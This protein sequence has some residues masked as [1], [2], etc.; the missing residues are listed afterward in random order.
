MSIDLDDLLRSVARRAG[1]P[2]APPA[3]V[4][5]LVEATLTALASELPTNDVRALAQS[6]PTPLDYALRASELQGEFF[7]RI[8]RSTFVDLPAATERA[9]STLRALGEVLPGELLSRI[10]RHLPPNVA[11]HLE[12]ESASPPPPHPTHANVRG[13]LASGRPGSA[14]PLSESRPMR[15]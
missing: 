11:R 14:H 12:R 13:N 7:E 15:K 9:E 2:A 8:A 3:E 10:I 4:L 1:I 6:L 5:G